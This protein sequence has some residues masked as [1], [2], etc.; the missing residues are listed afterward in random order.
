MGASG[1]DKYRSMLAESV[2]FEHLTPA[3]L[4]LVLRSCRLVDA[5]P[6][7]LLLSEGARGDGLY[8]ILDGEV[9]PSCPS[10]PSGT[11]AGPLGCVSAFSGSGAVSASTG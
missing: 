5:Q 1:L 6:G 7:Q 2:V 9:S 10:A 4:D 3:E 8:I 11:C